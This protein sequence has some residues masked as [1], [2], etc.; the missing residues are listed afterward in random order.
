ML[1]APMFQ[2]KNMNCQKYFPEMNYE[3]LAKEENNCNNQRHVERENMNWL[4]LTDPFQKSHVVKN[5]ANGFGVA[6][7]SA[8][9]HLLR[10]LQREDSRRDLFVFF[11]LGGALRKSFR[12][13][14][15]LAVYPVSSTSSRRAAATG[16]SFGSL[17]P[18]TSSHRNSP[19]ECRYWRTRRTR[20]SLKMGS[21][22][23]DPGC[24]MMSRSACT[25]PGS[26]T[27]SRCKRNT[28]PW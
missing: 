21:T 6:Q 28:L 7:C 14:D 18:A 25:P 10:L 23:T 27:V 19:I 20:P 3:W 22:T 8:L 11:R 24:T 13:E 12:C 5:S 2:E 1:H 15:R 4:D 16:V 17:R 26:I 9:D